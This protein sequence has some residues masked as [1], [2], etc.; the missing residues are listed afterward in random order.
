MR[1]PVVSGIFYDSEKSR[2]EKN[3]KYLFAGTKAGTFKGVVSPHAGY[4]YSG[5][6]AARAIASLESCGKFVILGPNHNLIGPGFSVMCSGEWKTPLGKIKVNEGLG[7]RLL[8]C[9]VLEEDEIA[10]G[11]EHSIEVQLPLMQ[12]RFSDFSFV[13]IS[14][15]NEGYSE[16]FL[17]DCE[18]LGKHMAKLTK[19]EQFGIVAS[20]DFSHY[21]P[22]KEADEKDAMALKM[23]MR[24][25]TKG[26]FR[27]LEDNAASVCGFGPIAVLM[28]AAKNL[29]LKAKLVHKSTSGDETGDYS[30]V[31]AYYALGFG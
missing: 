24:L 27:T 23:I 22:K 10:H 1:N 29:G 21:L 13:P 19:S 28:S 11:H 12:Y 9:G 16:Y 3:L 14:I 25:D 26:F 5:R 17:S 8:K 15:R 30:S 2:L 20:S 18:K 7:E 4:M 6:T 31:V